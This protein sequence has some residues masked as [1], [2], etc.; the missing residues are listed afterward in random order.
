MG[1]VTVSKTCDFLM[2]DQ[3]SAR[4]MKA[5]GELKEGSFVRAFTK[6]PFII[7]YKLSSL[8]NGSD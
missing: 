2:S 8:K 1:L 5:Y 4:I 3:M 6:S 7:M